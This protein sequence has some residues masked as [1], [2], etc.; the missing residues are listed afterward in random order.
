VSVNIS[1]KDRYVEMSISDNGKGFDTAKILNGNGMSTLK[2]RSSE[3]NAYFNIR[4]M[5]S[6]GTIVE[7]KFKIT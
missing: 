5:L 1:Q 4:S 6:E 3:L 2:R 7:L